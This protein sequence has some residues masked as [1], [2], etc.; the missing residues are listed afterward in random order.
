[1]LLAV[2]RVQLRLLL[3]ACSRRNNLMSDFDY[4]LTQLLK[5]E[6]GYANDP[7]DP[8]GETYKGISRV[9]WPNWS[10]WPLIDAA[11]TDPK[12]RE[13]LAENEHLPSL[14]NSFYRKNFWQFDGV[15]DLL[16]ASKLFDI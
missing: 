10:G 9:F 8:G 1:M 11:K 4:A 13:K 3:L 7:R 15:N 5:E 16:I 14:I 12:F 6:G 2:R